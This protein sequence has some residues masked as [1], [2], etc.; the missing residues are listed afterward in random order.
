[1]TKATTFHKILPSCGYFEIV[2]SHSTMYDDKYVNTICWY[3]NVLEIVKHT[4][5]TEFS[6][7]WFTAKTVDNGLSGMMLLR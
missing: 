6:H 3:T 5:F 4:S 1:M 7:I 2:P